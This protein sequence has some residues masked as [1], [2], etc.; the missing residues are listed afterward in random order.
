MERTDKKYF[1]IEGPIERL[2]SLTDSFDPLHFFQISLYSQPGIHLFVFNQETEFII[3][4]G[5][6]KVHHFPYAVLT[7]EEF[8]KLN[9]EEG[10]Y[11]QKGSPALSPWGTK[12][13]SGITGQ[14]FS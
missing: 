10:H 11:I 7:R 6:A 12:V 2:A 13:V 5:Y 14:P 4:R 1:R 9:P 8:L 3:A